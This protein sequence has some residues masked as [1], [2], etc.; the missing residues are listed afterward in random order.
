MTN[1]GGMGGISGGRPLDEDDA[2]E[3]AVERQLGE[4]IRADQ[5]VGVAL[6]SALA[7]QGWGNAAGDTASYSFRAA[8]DLIAAVAGEGD[9]LDYY[10]A[11]PYAVVS[12]QIAEALAREGW[13]PTDKEEEA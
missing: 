11:G 9:Y 10:C 12:D 1:Y 5:S 3:A 8:G 7:N 6:W 4:A 13:Y 2:F